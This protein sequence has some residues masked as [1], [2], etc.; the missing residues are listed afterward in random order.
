VLEY[1]SGYILLENFDCTLLC[2]FYYKNLD[3]KSSLNTQ[4]V[5][6]TLRPRV[7]VGIWASVRVNPS[8]GFLGPESKWEF[9]VLNVLILESESTEK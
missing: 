3:L 5:C 6:H 9:R 8:Q 7:R 2:T 1:N 4:S